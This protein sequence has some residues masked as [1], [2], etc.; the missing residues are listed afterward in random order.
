MPTVGERDDAG[1]AVN[2]PED[3]VGK[4]ADL[5]LSRTENVVESLEAGLG[6]VSKEFRLRVAPLA[7][8]GRLRSLGD[9]DIGS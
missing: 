2:Q 4:H 1:L 5:H 3:L 7:A 8:H 6:R 9:L